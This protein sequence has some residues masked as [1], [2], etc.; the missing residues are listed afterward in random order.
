MHRQLFHAT[1]L[2][3]PQVRQAGLLIT[4]PAQSGK[5]TLGWQLLAAGALLVSDDQ[6]MVTTAPQGL[7]A[8]APDGLAGLMEIG[9]YGIVH[10]P[11]QQ[12]AG[13]ATLALAITIIPEP[14]LLERLPDNPMTQI[15][16]VKLPHLMLRPHDPAAVAKI[17]A[18]LSCP[19]LDYTDV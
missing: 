7:I 11:P 12:L 18:V 19:L 13:M 6:T 4:G 2:L 5:T 16:A 3:L 10:L 8:T 1:C 9:G 15:L 14:Q 17:Q